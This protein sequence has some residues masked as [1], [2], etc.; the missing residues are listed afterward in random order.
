MRCFKHLQA[1][2]NLII[3]GTGYNPANYTQMPYHIAFS[4]QMRAAHA[5]G[6]F[7]VKKVRVAF[8]EG[9][10]PRALVNFVGYAAI[11]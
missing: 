6:R 8:A 7:A 1:I 11:A 9:K 2:L 5:A 4:I 10:L 3:I